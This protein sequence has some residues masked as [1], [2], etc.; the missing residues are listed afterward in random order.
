MFTNTSIKSN[1]PVCSIIYLPVSKNDFWCKKKKHRYKV[2]VKRKRK[3]GHN[4][5]SAPILHS[6]EFLVDYGIPIHIIK[7]EWRTR[8]K[9]LFYFLFKL[10]TVEKCSTRY[11]LWWKTHT[12]L[13]YYCSNW[14]KHTVW[15]IMHISINLYSLT[16]TMNEWRKKIKK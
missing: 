10:Q 16:L 9:S 15:Y 8:K 13:V 14:S 11:F 4:S 6:F 5:C 7:M 3:F 12:M 2:F 1:I